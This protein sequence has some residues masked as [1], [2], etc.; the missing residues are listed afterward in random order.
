MTDRLELDIEVPARLAGQR[1]DQ[2]AAEL[3]PDYSRARLQGWIRGGQLTL[4]GRTA[5]PRDKLFGG[6]TLRLRAQ[7]EPQGEWQAEDIPLDIAYEDQ[8]LL[9]VNKPAGLVVHPAAGNPRGTLLNALLHHAPQLEKVP[10]AGIVHRLDKDT[11]GLLVVAKTLQAQ[12]SLVDQLKERSVGRRYQALVQGVLSGGGSVD[13]P[14]GRHRQ[15]RLKMAVLETGGRE[16]VTHYRVAERFRAH[17]LLCCQLETGRTHQIRVHMAHIRHPLVGDPLYGGRP[18]L[19]LDAGGALV[20][21]LQ[22]FP[23]QA[24]HA[25]ELVL[26]HPQSGTTMRW[27]RPVPDDMLRLLTLL[28]ED[29]P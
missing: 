27:H 1:L 15:N 6:E 13:A 25:E 28:R 21:E 24:L 11:S 22:Q 26:R 20:A 10:R 18:R 23:R 14:I 5:R 29:A 8:T 2:A 12:T 9:V 4:D 3:I 16:A 19:P 7:L 17:T